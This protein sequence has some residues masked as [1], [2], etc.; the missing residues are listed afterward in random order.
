MRL[1]CEKRE[2]L[3]SNFFP[4]NKNISKIRK[5]AD[6]KRIMLTIYNL[7]ISKIIIAWK[8]SNDKTECTFILAS[9]LIFA[10]LLLLVFHFSGLMQLWRII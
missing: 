1:I 7:I 6:P 8:K 9:S 10:L 5:I 3:F 2:N 4:D